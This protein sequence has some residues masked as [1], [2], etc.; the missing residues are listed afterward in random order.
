MFGLAADM[1]RFRFARAA[2]D[3][4]H[5]GLTTPQELADYLEVHRCRGKDGVQRLEQW[6]ERNSGRKRPSQSHLEM[7]FLES[8]ARAG[9]PEPLRQHPVVLPSGETVHLDIAWPKIKLAV[10]PGSAWF[11]GGDAGQARDHD[12]D[13]ACAEVGWSVI[14]LDET[15]AADPQAASQRV[16]RAY[17]R[18][19]AEL[20]QAAG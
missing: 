9:L 12:R 19:H 2:E 13:L 3:A 15:F 11:H 17:H 5:L 6:L 18:R 20:R 10:E 14:R 16:T 4:W 1:N 8:F 7:T